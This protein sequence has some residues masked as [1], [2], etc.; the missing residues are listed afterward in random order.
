MGVPGTPGVP[1]EIVQHTISL[2]YNDLEAVRQA[3]ERVGEEVAAII[4]EPVAANMGVC[5]PESDICEGLRR[6]CTE[7]GSLLIF[8]GVITVSG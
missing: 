3:M 8:D 2:P 5:C 7:H 4:V 6:I 1:E